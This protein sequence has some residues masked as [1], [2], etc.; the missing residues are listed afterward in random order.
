MVGALPRS[1]QEKAGLDQGW[2]LVPGGALCC[3]QWACSR[4]FG[5]K[6]SSLFTGP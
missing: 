2:V 6:G 5:W 3:R 4:E 1:Q